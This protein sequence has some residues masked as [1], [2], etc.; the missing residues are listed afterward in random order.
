MRP[1]Y[2]RIVI[3]SLQAHEI[4]VFGSKAS[5]AHGAGA[6]LFREVPSNIVL[7]DEFR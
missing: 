5:G 3:S 4:F 6:P 7:P 1:F 2:A